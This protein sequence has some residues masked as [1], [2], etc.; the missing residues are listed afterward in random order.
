ML[1]DQVLAD[2]IKALGDSIEIPP[3]GV[4]AILLRARPDEE[5]PPTS[6]KRQSRLLAAAV[7][8]IVV[9][10]SGVFALAVRH[11]GPAS[12]SNHALALLPAEPETTILAQSNGSAGAGVA[13]G[14]AITSPPS[15]TVPT[16]VVKTGEID[17]VVPVRQVTP[18]IS[19]L[20]TIAAGLGGF[21]QDS[22]SAEA[23]SDPTGDV[24]LRIPSD[25]FEAAVAKVRALGTPTSITTSGQDVTSQYVD[26]QARIASLQASRTR[27]LEILGKA[28]TIGDIL[29]VQ[30]QID[31]IQ[32]QIEQD[33]GQLNVLDTQTS[34]STLAVHVSTTAL[35]IAVPKTQ[36]GW[37]KAWTHAR[38]SFSGGF[39]SL[40]SAS[41][42]IAVFLL[43]LGALGLLARLVWA[44]V[45]RRLV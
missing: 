6:I 28:Q 5:A 45:R 24:T 22:K 44:V 2:A 9:G 40:V 14:P 13:G 21:V 1:D 33:Q 27:Y 32:S 18:T 25:Q 26:L 12:T 43:C 15:P 37:S 42:G 41:G 8:V 29:S 38:H 35:A 7:L 34:Y 23:T 36:S 3:G 19:Q 39:E 31:T 10:I 4:E 17:L 11:G 20:S 30:Q 16:K